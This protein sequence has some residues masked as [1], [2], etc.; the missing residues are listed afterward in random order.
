MNSFK[1]DIRQW[2]REEIEGAPG[3][4][5]A[6]IVFNNL[7][8]NDFH[9]WFVGN[10]EGN[11]LYTVMLSNEEKAIVGFTDERIASNYINRTNITRQIRKSF[12][13][14]VVLVSMSLH[15]ISEIMQNNMTA[16]ISMGPN[17]LMHQL[18]KS[19]IQTVIVNPN[20]HD[21]FVPLNIPYI[22]QR[23]Q[24]SDDVMQFNIDVKKEDKEL[25]LYEID[26]ESKKYVF[27]P[28]GSFGD[29]PESDHI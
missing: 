9:M 10:V 11:Q 24:E 8:K 14:K 28:D 23:Y 21:F 15:K 6:Q 22:M 16:Q 17:V 1:E 19:P 5:A 29:G 18:I 26:D 20:D 25:S 7:I 2:T 12:G 3:R 27:C 13:P 4:L